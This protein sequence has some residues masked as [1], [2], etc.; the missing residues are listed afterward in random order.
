MSKRGRPAQFD[1]AKAL[2]SAMELFW[3]RG[4]EGATL[5]DLQAAMGG[6]SPPSFYNAFGSKEALFAE[7]VELYVSTIAAPP[8]C[9]LQQGRTARDG[10]DAM[11]RESVE[12]FSTPGKPQGCLLLSGAMNCRP[13]NNGSWQH[14]RELRQGTSDMIELRLHRAIAEGELSPNI[15]VAAIAEFYTTV[16]HGLS[17]RA[18]DRAPRA[19]LIASVECAMQAWDRLLNLERE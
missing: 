14:L 11:L 5:E 7:V 16:V 3:A 19:K 17:V 8:A 1:R 4:Y 10:I 15:D 18:G 12:S 9:A 2:E 6:I 13:A